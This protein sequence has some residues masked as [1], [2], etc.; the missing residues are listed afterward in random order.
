[1]VG[2]VGAQWVVGSKDEGDPDLAFLIF[3]C[4]NN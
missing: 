4:V 2:V 3:V 1:M